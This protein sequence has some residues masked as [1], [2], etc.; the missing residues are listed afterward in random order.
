MKKERIKWIDSLKGFAT[1][2]VVIGHI[3]DGYLDASIFPE[4]DSFL[5]SVF[6]FIYMFHMA[7]FFSISGMTYYIAYGN[8]LK[9]PIQKR[10]RFNSQILNLVLLYVL[11]CFVNWGFKII[12]SKYVNKPV[13]YTDI[14][15]IV[16]RPIYQYWYF[17]VL[18]FLYL[19]IC[20]IVRK[21]INSNIVTVVLIITS[22]FSGFFRDNDWFQITH[23]LFYAIFFWIGINYIINKEYWI[24]KIIVIIIS[25][26]ISLI[27]I[28]ICF[29][30]NII[31]YRAP[32]INCIVAFGI[33][34]IL[35]CLFSNFAVFEKM[36]F[37]NFIGKYSLEIYVLHCFFTAGNRVLLPKIG[38]TS[39]Y[40]CIIV[41]L[42]IS[43][44]VPIL[45]AV[46]TRKIGIYNL[47]FA[48]Y[49]LLKRK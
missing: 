43:T 46:V 13:S 35:I 39:F 3:V 45:F 37:F 42:I 19:I 41:N 21:N 9:E 5:Q 48:P 24:Y 36:K 2:L 28:I 32:I 49:K 6:N 29:L 26:C 25:G 38:I 31:I 33:V 22:L 14:L 8:E 40:V 7:L 15:F 47:F 11:Y 17:Y 30:N 1:I 27:T 34:L 10:T 23:I 20:I 12:L 44:A 18:I 4:Y 16:A